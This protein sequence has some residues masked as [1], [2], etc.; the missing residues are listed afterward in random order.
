MAV[1]M[2]DM[3]TVVAEMTSG[4]LRQAGNHLPVSSSVEVHVEQP[5][6]SV[7]VAKITRVTSYRDAE[8]KRDTLVLHV[9]EK[10]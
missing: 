1:D 8:T 4:A 2:Q 5:D 3:K 9:R 6:G 7:T 10:S